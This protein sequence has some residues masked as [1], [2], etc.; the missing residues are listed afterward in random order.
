MDSDRLVLEFLLEKDQRLRLRLRAERSNRQTI[1][2]D[3]GT[4]SSVSASSS[5]TVFIR[6]GG[7]AISKIPAPPSAPSVP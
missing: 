7:E 1:F 4:S 2:G 3:G 6:G 5:E